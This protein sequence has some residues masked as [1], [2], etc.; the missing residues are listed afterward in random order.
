MAPLTIHH[1]VRHPGAASVRD[2]RTGSQLIREAEPSNSTSSTTVVAQ[3]YRPLPRTTRCG[4]DACRHGQGVEA[5]RESRR[6][7]ENRILCTMYRPIIHDGSIVWCD[8]LTG[9][10]S[11]LV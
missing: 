8:F 5:D 6:W 7:E 10:E 11:R 3:G 9:R 4:A 2:V 1:L